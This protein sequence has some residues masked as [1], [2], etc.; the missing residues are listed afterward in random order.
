MNINQSDIFVLLLSASAFIFQF[1]VT[2][3]INFIDVLRNK[4]PFVHGA[5]MLSMRLTNYIF[6]GLLL[7]LSLLGYLKNVTLVHYLYLFLC[8]NISAKVNWNLFALTDTSMHSRLLTVIYENSPI[9]HS[10]LLNLYN[11]QT[12]FEARLPR[13]L[14]LNQLKIENGT[15]YLSGKFVLIG[16]SILAFFRCLLGIPIRPKRV[17]DDLIENLPPLKL[18]SRI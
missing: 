18:R 12:I 15:I 8:I 2:A 10:S 9:S 11:R 1:L 4:A 3:L 6:L 7:A 14:E 16:A 5:S 13:L 17:P